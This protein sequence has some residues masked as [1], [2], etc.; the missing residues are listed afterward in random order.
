MILPRMQRKMMEDSNLN[1]LL[2]LCVSGAGGNTCGIYPYLF[3][4]L[5]MLS[6][7]RQGVEVCGEFV[8]SF[9]GIFCELLS[10]EKEDGEFSLRES[11]RDELA[12]RLDHIKEELTEV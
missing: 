7:E 5:N 1:N 4:D 11:A 3:V 12:G 2:T 9:D 6:K 10:S 8:K